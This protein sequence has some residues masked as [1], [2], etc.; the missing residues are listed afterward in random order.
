MVYSGLPFSE[1]VI[2]VI[3]FGLESHLCTYAIQGCDL[4]YSNCEW[5]LFV[6]KNIKAKFLKT[7][8]GELFNNLRQNRSISGMPCMLAFF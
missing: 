3:R 2:V 7:N 4:F 8:L 6:R 5:L 1:L